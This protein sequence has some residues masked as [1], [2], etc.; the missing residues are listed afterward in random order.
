MAI[1]AR[2]LDLLRLYVGSFAWAPFVAFSK[3]ALLSQLSKIR[4]GQLVVTDE[5]GEVTVCGASEPSDENA[6]TEL[7]VAKEAFWVRVVLFADMVGAAMPLITSVVN[8][9]LT[10]CAYQGFAES[11]MLG[12]ISSPDLVAFFRV[13]VL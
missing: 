9:A 12:E 3:A 2:S 10:A 11:F 7:L 4:A 1:V 8:V 5:N 13:R 6:R